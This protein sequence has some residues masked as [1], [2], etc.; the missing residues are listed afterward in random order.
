MIRAPLLTQIAEGFAGRVPYA[1]IAAALTG[2]AQRDTPN[3]LP[4]RRGRGGFA[5]TE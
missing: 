2:P 4:D 3:S 1:P 5:L